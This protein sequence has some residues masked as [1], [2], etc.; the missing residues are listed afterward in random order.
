VFDI[1]QSVFTRD[2]EINERKAQKYSEHLIEEFAK[3]PEGKAIEERFGRV[4]GWVDL[5]FEYAFNYI[6]V[7]LTDLSTDN[8]REVL[9]ELFPRKVSTDAGDAPEIVAEF[10][11]FWE[12]LKRQYGLPVANIIDM[13]DDRAERRLRDELANPANFGMAKSFFV[14]GQQAGFDMST[15]EGIN[16]F[17]AAYNAGQMNRPMPMPGM[18]DD[19]EDDFDD[20]DDED[21]F[22]DVPAPPPPLSPAQ[23]SRKRKAR[24]AQRQA[25]KRNRRK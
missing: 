4:G 7:D 6:G 13:L 9:F 24:K 16:A 15:Q 23:R 20:F 1:S 14:Q 12:F 21:D 2:G 22:D 17:M 11:A 3:A 5:M 8:M 18:I 19:D 25:R 10:H